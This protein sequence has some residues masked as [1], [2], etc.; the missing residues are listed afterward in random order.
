MNMQVDKTGQQ[1]RQDFAGRHQRD[2]LVN[3]RVRVN[4]VQAHPDAQ[5]AECFAQFCHASFNRRTVPE[6]GAV[7]DVDAISTGV[8]GNHQQLFNAGLDQ[9]LGFVE[10]V[11]NRAADQ[12]TAQ[13]RDGAG[14]THPILTTHYVKTLV[15][16]LDIGE[17]YKKRLNNLLVNSREAQWRKER[18]VAFK[19]AQLRLDLLE[20]TLSGVLS[21]DQAARVKTALDYPVENTRPRLN[22]E[23]IKVHLLMMRYKPLPGVLVFSSTASPQ[24]LCYT[25]DAPG[26]R[27]FLIADSRNELGRMLSHQVWR[28]YV[29]HRVRPVQQAYL[30]PLL[31]Q[32]LTESNLQ[33][34][35]ITYNML[36]ASY[37]TEALHALHNADE[38]STSTWESNLNTAKET[39][40]TAID[41]VS[42]VLPTRVLLPIVLARFIYQIFLGIDALQ[43]D[44]KHEALLQFMESITHL[45]DAASDFTGSTIFRKSI[46]QRIPQ[47]TPSLSTRGVSTPPGTSLKLRTG[48]EFSAGVYESTP[49]GGGQQ[50]VRPITYLLFQLTSF[51]HATLFS[52]KECKDK[53]LVQAKRND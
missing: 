48:D 18:Y 49:A 4:V 31:E 27:W 24:L 15:R 41:V 50:S 16:Q 6:T 38:Q 37:D 39:A 44:E 5:S 51:N 35:A 47:P 53:W 28:P 14:N 11:A 22:G 13:V 20:A 43:R 17:N 30:K 1:V 9:A 21:A 7:L 10:H 32:G 23:Q 3:V 45:T 19:K 36:E 29:L 46:R 52:T 34:Q 40:L 2:Q 26:K 25:P 12:F 33:L 8:L 42:F